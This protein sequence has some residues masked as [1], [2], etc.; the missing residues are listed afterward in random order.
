MT[1]LLPAPLLLV[2]EFAEKSAHDVVELR[3]EVLRRG[4]VFSRK[5]EVLQGANQVA[6][7]VVAVMVG[8]DEHCTSGGEAGAVCGV[9]H[10]AD[11]A[12]AR[13]VWLPAE[14]T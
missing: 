5:D 13:R 3:G 2:D 9:G 7:T 8:E 11:D 4:R 12:R 10:A 14:A 6:S 1:S